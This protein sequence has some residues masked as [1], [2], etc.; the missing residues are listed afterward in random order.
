[1]IAIIGPPNAGKSSLLNALAKR[2]AAIVSPIPGT[3]RDVIEVHLD[4]GGYAVTIADTAGL[5]E[6][7]D[8]IE[9]EGIKRAKRRA[10][11]ADVKI[12]LFDGAHY[13]A[14]DAVTAAMVDEGTLSVFNKSDLIGAGRE[15]GGDVLF[16]SA[17]TG[18]GLDEFAA[19]MLQHVRSKADTGAVVPLT[20]ARHRKALEDC[21]EA[22]LRA[23]AA[24]LPELAAEDLRLAARA[25]GRLTGRVDVEEIL[26]VVFRDFCIG[27]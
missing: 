17:K 5:R 24:D 16:I 22:L 14:R 13:P 27:K 25:L 26:D 4:L 21:R 2:E 1:M 3:T 9:D 10:A 18:A 19:V 11:E 12:A 20:R 15:S 7:G 23:K 8:A 6:A